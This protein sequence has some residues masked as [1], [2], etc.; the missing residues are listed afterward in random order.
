MLCLLV[1]ARNN[2]ALVFLMAIVAMAGW[3][4]GAACILAWHLWKGKQ[5]KR[6]PDRFEPFEIRMVWVC[7]GKFSECYH[8]ERQE[9][10]V[11]VGSV[12]D[13][14]AAQAETFHPLEQKHVCLCAGCHFV[15][16]PCFSFKR[17]GETMGGGRSRPF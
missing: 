8:K 7:E 9:R 4:C 10:C 16:P 6:D 2:T 5:E 11:G 15:S 14:F 1:L 17:F 12:S 3:L 13:V